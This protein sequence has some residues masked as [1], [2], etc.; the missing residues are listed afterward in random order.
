MRGQLTRKVAVI[1]GTTV[2]A[3][4]ATGYAVAQSG[5]DSRDEERK[6]FLDDAAQRLDKSP[7]ELTKALQDAAI[8]RIDA[9]VKEGRLT[10]AQADE[11]K[12][13][14]KQ[15]DGLGFLGG[16]GGPGG[17][18]H[19]HGGP[20]RG[21]GLEAAAKYLGL[22]AAE[23][24]ERHE[25]GKSLADVAKERNKSV[26]GLKDAMEKAIRADIAD[27]VKDKRLTQEQADQILEDLPERLDDKIERTG[28][29]HGR[30]GHGGPGGPGGPGFGPPP[31]DMPPPGDV[32]PPPPGD[33][34]DDN[35]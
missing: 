5:G 2:I 15:G 20:G 17:P 4:G 18:G 33:A 23:L 10:Q 28:P 27:A 22:S 34:P 16:R 25:D 3:L 19:H 13:R 6:A 12:Q 14:V 35:G 24:H 31:G 32:P 29:P 1:A 8:A 30:G 21:A 7:E 26:E 9:A 11:M